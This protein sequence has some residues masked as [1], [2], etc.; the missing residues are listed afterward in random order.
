MDE[1]HSDNLPPELDELG[2]RMSTERPVASDRTLDRVMTR[3]Q[4]ARPARKSSL[5]WRSTAPRVRGKVLALGA[6]AILAAAGTVGM[7]TGAAMAQYELGCPAGTQF[8]SV[9]AEV[10]DQ[11]PPNL[12]VV[13][14][15]VVIGNLLGVCARVA[16]P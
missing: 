2:K 8:I 4:G 3:A 14:A 9:I 16:I 11:L 7:T 12:L 1:L 5:M 15:D 10:G 13:N 6:G